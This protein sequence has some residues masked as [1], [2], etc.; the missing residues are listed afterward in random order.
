MEIQG[1]AP[2][3]TEIVADGKAAGTLYTQSGGWAIAYLRLDRAQGAMNAGPHRVRDEPGEKQIK[4]DQR[5]DDQSR[6][7][8]GYS[9]RCPP[10]QSAW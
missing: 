7:K 2:V 9:S 10:V 4:Q 5:E 8:P 1:T 6:G 3:G